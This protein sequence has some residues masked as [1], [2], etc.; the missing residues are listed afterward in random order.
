M[1]DLEVRIVLAGG[2]TAD[3]GD[4]VRTADV[5]FTAFGRLKRKDLVI[6][7]IRSGRL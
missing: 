4:I 5:G 6:N 2:E 7:K 1:A 3:V